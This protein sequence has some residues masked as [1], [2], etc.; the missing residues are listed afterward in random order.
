MQRYQR[1]WGRNDKQNIKKTQKERDKTCIWSSGDS[2]HTFARKGNSVSE[3]QK[4]Q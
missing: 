1:E 3:E 2:F 4:R